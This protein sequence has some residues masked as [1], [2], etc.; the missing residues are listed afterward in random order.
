MAD[1]RAWI[2][3]LIAVQEGRFP[4][5]LLSDSAIADLLASRPRIALVGASDNPG[6]PSFGV[7]AALLDIGYD[8][9]PVNPGADEV[10][11]RRCYPTVEDAARGT[12]PIA[13]VDVFRR[14][15][16]CEEHARDAV[17]A[18]AACLWLQLGIASEAA[19][20]IAHDAGLGVVMDRC[21]LIEH[22]RLLGGRRW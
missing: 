15:S 4:V 11:G 1:D 19:G 12:G 2:A 17:A 22:R 14:P 21:T 5:P 13:L 6:R 8:V 10:Q 7:M 16:S 3:D 20:R 18:G 9:V